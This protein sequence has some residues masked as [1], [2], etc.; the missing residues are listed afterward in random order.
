MFFAKREYL[1]EHFTAKQRL[2]CEYDRGYG[3]PPRFCDCKYS[4]RECV[5]SSEMNGCPELR[6]IVEILKGLSDRQFNQIVKKR[7]HSLL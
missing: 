6:C 5:S 1:I 4:L 7:G 2:A 3:E